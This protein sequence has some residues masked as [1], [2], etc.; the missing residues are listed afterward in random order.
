MS[1]TFPFDCDAWLNSLSVQTMSSAE[2][3]GYIQLLCN[4]WIQKDRCFLPNDDKVLQKLSGM[5][6]EEWSSSKETVLRNFV[7]DGDRLYNERL[8]HEARKKTERRKRWPKKWQIPEELKGLALYEKDPML[9]DRF[10]ELVKA[11]KS[12]YPGLDIIK[13]VKKAH[14]W[15]LTNPKRRKTSNGRSRFLN[16]WMERAQNRHRPMHVE[17]QKFSDAIPSQE[18]QYNGI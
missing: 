8:L 9:C 7:V 14:I 11:W 3:G 12:A 1:T 4:S 16:S 15:E 17:R 2:R 6:S 18:G 10:P 13:E 5:T